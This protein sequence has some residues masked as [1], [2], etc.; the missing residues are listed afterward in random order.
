MGSSRYS[1]IIGFLQEETGMPRV[2]YLVAASL[3]GFIA[4]PNGEIDWIPVDPDFD[5]ATLYSQFDTI[6]VGRRTFEE[7]LRVGQPTMP[8]VQTIVFSG[9]L[10]QHAHPGVMIVADQQEEAVAR[11][12]ANSRKDIWLFG[13]GALFRSLAERGLVDA[14]EVSVVPVLLGSGTPLLPGISKPLQLTLTG[15]KV[16]SKTGIVSLEYNLEYNVNTT[17]VH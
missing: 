7:M 17:G 14:V 5:F 9:T 15:H 12:R 3:D 6:L 4:G 10:R 13:G 16:Y 8:G 1:L 2:R 11:L